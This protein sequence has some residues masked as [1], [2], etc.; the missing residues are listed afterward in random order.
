MSEIFRLG[1]DTFLSF[2]KVFLT[3]GIYLYEYVL[4]NFIS[5]QLVEEEVAIF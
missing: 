1:P 5:H 3:A 4:E 2:S